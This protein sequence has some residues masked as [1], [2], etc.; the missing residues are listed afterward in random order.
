VGGSINLKR[1]MQVKLYK[2]NKAERQCRRKRKR[3]IFLTSRNS[4]LMHRAHQSRPVYASSSG[5]GTLLPPPCPF[6]E[7]DGAAAARM[8]RRRVTITTTY[9]WH[10][11][12]LSDGPGR[13][14][15]KMPGTSKIAIRSTARIGKKKGI[16]I[17]KDAGKG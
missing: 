2:Y 7:G 8:A 5:G 14:R 1:K 3:K 12:L 10:Q 15:R 13:P 17:G 6:P 4:M 9:G 11:I 16:R